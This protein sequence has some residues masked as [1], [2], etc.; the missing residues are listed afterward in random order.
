MEEGYTK[1]LVTTEIMVHSVV[2]VEEAER[3]VDATYTNTIYDG[4][5]VSFN[6][7]EMISFEIKEDK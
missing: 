2:N 6:K 3:I 5:L 7:P 4:A 1:I